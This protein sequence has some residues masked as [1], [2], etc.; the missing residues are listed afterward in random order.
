MGPPCVAHSPAGKR[1]KFDDPRTKCHDVAYS[2]AD[3]CDY[4]L[5]FVENVEGYPMEEETQKVSKFDWKYA[6]VDPRKFGYPMART[7]KVAVGVN[8]KTTCWLDATSTLDDLVA[9]FYMKIAQ[10][11][12]AALYYVMPADDILKQYGEW[13]DPCKPVAGMALAQTYK[14]ALEQYSSDP[15]YKGKQMYDLSCLPKEGRGRCEV[16]DLAGP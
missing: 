15:K 13:Y 14:S 7:R 10:P 1:Q 3:Q 8:K 6:V 16:Q 11:D 9:P 4:D 5:V 12:L 2:I